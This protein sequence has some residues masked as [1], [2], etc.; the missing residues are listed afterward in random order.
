[1]TAR[2]VGPWR[3]LSVIVLGVHVVGA[4]GALAMLP[5]GFAIDD[6]HLWSNT[7]LPVGASLAVIASVVA[8]RR[9]PAAIGVVMA[10]CAGGW[11]AAVASGAILFPTS[12]PP[13]RWAV[14]AIVAGVLAA[15][16]WRAAVHRRGALVA[17]GVGAGLGVLVILAQR[18]P[19][20]STRP[21]GGTHPEVTG[22]PTVDRVDR[23]SACGLRISP[24][25]TFVSRSP[26]RTWTILAPGPHGVRRELRRYQ[27]L[28]TGYAAAFDDDGHSTLVV[29][30]HAGG[31][32]LDAMTT[33]DVP[34][35]SHLNSFTTIEVPLD[36]TIAFGPIAERFP[37]EPADYPSGRPIRLAYLA[38]DQLHVARARDA[39]KGPFEELGRGSLRRGEPLVIEL[40]TAD[41][42]CRLTFDD[43]SA[44]VSDEPSPTAGWGV[45][46]NSIQFFSNI[47][48]IALAETGPGRGF[49]A[50]G[51]AAGTYR[52]RV[53][54]E[55]LR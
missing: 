25:L 26:D 16:A 30:E 3:V 14:P 42:D 13:A 53:R 44:Q 23:I 54:V 34:I 19:L 21:A 37:I 6:L 41:H 10:A 33:L 18:A 45:P 49:D 55:V 5:R 9:I 48:V 36:A 46:Q 22:E 2:A 20:P 1:M 28:A 15:L 38:G 29:R 7:V 32:E 52:N 50:V 47:V 40:R 31:V 17:A 24:L 11:I 12:I 4:I 8:W 51:H 27:P 43:W 35:Y 39:E